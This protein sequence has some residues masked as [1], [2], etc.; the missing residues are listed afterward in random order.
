MAEQTQNQD[1]LRIDQL[2]EEL[3]HHN[4]QYYV[5]DDPTIPDVEYD[6]LMR[7][8]KTLEEK[9]PEKYSENSP[10][11]RV[12]GKVLDK[13]EKVE[14]LAPMLSLSDA[15]EDE[16]IEQFE[17]FNEKGLGENELE[18]SCEP[19]FDGLAISLVYEKGILVRAATRG[20]GLVGENVTENV[21]TIKNIPLDISKKCLEQ[22]IAIPELLEVRGE[23]VMLKKDFEDLNERQREN[24][25]KTFAN[26]RNAAAG[27]LRQ[28]DSKI[29]AQRKLTF[30]AYALGKE[31]GIDLETDD[32]THSQN[33]EFLNKLGFPVSKYNKVVIGKDGLL[34]YFKE[35]G[36]IRDDLPF[37]IDGVV[38]KVNSIAK[39][40]IMGF[41]EKTPRWGKAH[42]YP[43]QEQ[44]TKII[45]IDIQ[46]GRTGA[47]T[48]VA[49]LEPVAVGGVVISNA[50]LHNMDEIERKDI[51]IGD[52]VRVRRA[53]DV[54][55]EVVSAVIEKRDLSVVK[56]FTM[57][58]SCPCCGSLVVRPSGEAVAR[59]TGGLVCKEQLKGQLAHFVSRKA[60]NINN[61]GDAIIEKMVDLELITNPADLYD[62]TMDDLLKIDLVKEKMATK[63]LENIEVS[64]QRNVQQFVYGLG[65]RQVGEGTSKDLLNHFKSLDKLRVATR[66]EILSI[67]GIGEATVDE[68][69]AFFQN[70]RNEEIIDRLNAKGVGVDV[71]EIKNVDGL[72]L[73]GK[74]FVITGSFEVSRDEIKKQLE[75]LGGKVSGS[76]SKK[77]DFVFVGSEA[78]S[79]L[80]KAKE[81]NLNIVEGDAQVKDF[82][83]QFIVSEQEKQ[84][85]EN[86]N[87]EQDQDQNLQKIDELNIEEKIEKKLM[88]DRIKAEEQLSFSF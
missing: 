86:K 76:V 21:R 68:V 84:L 33:M 2:R 25:Q 1:Y 5:Y 18:F 51:R 35:I 85:S 60:M 30:F 41:T 65:I 15:F 58:S 38:Y 72:P 52:V 82:F 23:I 75:E 22:N 49:R 43:A 55:P 53:G 59:C 67:K 39:Q 40:K 3:N 44:L 36:E 80:D 19:K 56:K 83:N 24:G 20:D 17:S 57:P 28:L 61:V 6:K 26:P 31:V 32:R 7:E 62:L 54:I 70:P 74:T 63:I 34:N 87:Q 71:L 47:L 78:G 64:K 10:T 77:T 8:L 81:L 16:E 73:T 79:K 12:G 37:D 42:K 88:T 29:T 4:I 14:H 66:E 69:V 27:S 45:D 48:P 13:F 46:V 50:T 9:Y 11:L